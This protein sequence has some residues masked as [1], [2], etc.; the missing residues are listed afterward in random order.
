MLKWTACWLLALAALPAL[1]HAQGLP[2]RTS[3]GGDFGIQVFG[4]TF[5]ADRNGTF[6]LWLAG[7]KIGLA[8]SITQ[9]LDDD[10]HWNAD[11]RHAAGATTFSS[12]A[13]GSNSGSSETL[14]ELRF[15][16]GRD[17]V[18]G[19]Q[20]FVP[21]AGLG[22]R[23]VLSYLKGYTDASYISPTRNG[24]LVY[25]PIGMIH[26]YRLADDARLATTVEYDHLLQGSQQTQYTEIVGYT[27]DLNVT[28]KTG[29]GARLNLAYETAHWST[30][31]F[32]HYWHID[33]SETGT[34]ANASTVFSTTEARNISRE[35]GIQLKYRFYD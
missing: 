9:T 29:R 25:L 8:G 27:S 16:V 1:V 15:T 5:D 3:T 23:T 35:L 28:Q 33:E 24:F 20:V 4:H 21:Y 10:W 11:A 26:R 22:Y 32:F 6:D 19:R 2:L 34:Y 14:T 18:A 17:L 31:V 7:R 13:R 30:S 12:A